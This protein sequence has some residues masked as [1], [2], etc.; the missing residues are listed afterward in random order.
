MAKTGFVRRSPDNNTIIE[1]KC[2]PSVKGAKI[3]SFA[4]LNFN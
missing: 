3:R 2:G 4:A 1:S